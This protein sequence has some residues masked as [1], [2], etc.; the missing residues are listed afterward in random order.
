MPENVDDAARL[1][2]LVELLPLP[3]GRSKFWRELATAA[4]E[5][6]DAL[7]PANLQAGVVQ[8]VDG[9]TL[10]LAM[11]LTYVVQVMTDADREAAAVVLGRALCW[12]LERIEDE[13]P[14]LGRMWLR[15]V[16]LTAWR[17]LFATAPQPRTD[18]ER[19][20]FKRVW[21]AR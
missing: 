16:E 17:V 13:N 6:G 1:L 8:A 7:L 3:D 14:H 20:H 9:K 21:S 4:G 11:Q 5:N 2:R 10:P 12:P 15:D 19:E 18:E